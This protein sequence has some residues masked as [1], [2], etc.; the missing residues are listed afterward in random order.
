MANPLLT[1]VIPVYNAAHFLPEAVESIRRQ[2]YEPVEIIVVDDGSTDNC[3]EVATGLGSN[4][5]YAR[6]ENAGPAAARNHGLSLARGEFISFLD[7]DDLWPP[8]KLSIQ[9]ARLLAEPELDFV[10]GR[11]QYQALPGGEIPNILFEGPENTIPPTV[12]GSGVYRRRVFDRIGVFEESLRFAED[13][14]WFMR[15]L[16]NHVEMRILR[17][18][19]LLYRLHGKNMTLD[20]KATSQQLM[21]AL[22][23]SMQ[24]QRQRG[25]AA[26][27]LRPWLS[28]DEW[29][30]GTPALVSVII[31]A[32]D[33]ARFVEEAIQSVLGQTYRPVEILVVDDGSTDRTVEKV[34]E[35]G[36]RLR[37]LR[38]DH[39]GLGA[40]LNLGVT[41]ATGRYIAFLDA[42]DLWPPTKLS[43]QMEILQKDSTCDLLFGHAQQFRETGGDSGGPVPG[44]AHSTMLARREVF[45]KTGLMSTDLK[46]GEFIDWYARAMEAGLR[47]RL[48]PEVWLRRRIHGANMTV[49][50]RNA[51]GD[52][53]RVVKAAMDRRRHA[54]SEGE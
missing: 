9:M 43:R 27:R 19:T 34:R 39:A 5:R 20:R 37:L 52:Y 7:A 13:M 38:Q 18:P 1:V 29:A 35:F 2:E 26:V 28:Y 16:E 4:V 22:Q 31:P 53:V 24:R 36:P 8:H 40:A 12:V 48:E 54:E 23:R 10:L 25:G 42:D 41:H 51:W 50:E 45:D 47:S 3:A 6:Q 44:Y 17:P 32:Y 33:A 11:T 14:D 49:R 46:V 15:A 21:V 30:P